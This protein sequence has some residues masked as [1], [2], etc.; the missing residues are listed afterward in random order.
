MSTKAIILSAAL[1]VVYLIH[2]IAFGQLLDIQVFADKDV[3][4]IGDTIAVSASGHNLGPGMNV[5]VH[6]AILTPDGSIHEAP[7]WNT[8]FAPFLEDFHLP[9]SFSYPKSDIGTYVVGELGFPASFP[10]DYLL[11]AAL[12]EPWTLEFLTEVS[13]APFRIEAPAVPGEDFLSH[14]GFTR[15]FLYYVP[16]NLP[17][18][19]VPLVFML[20]GAMSMSEGAMYGTTEERFNRLADRDKV[21]VVYPQAIDG[22]WNDCF[23]R[24][25]DAPDDVGFISSLIDHLSSIHTIDAQRIYAAGY[26]NGGMMSLR[27]AVELSGK[28]AAV[29]STNG[30]LPLEGE[31][32]DPVN[33]VGVLY[34]GG[35]DDP[36]VPFDGSDS[37]MSADETVDFWVSFL[38]T[39]A[40]PS[41]MQIPDTVPEDD[42]TVTVYTYSNGREQTQVSFYRI[43]GGGHPWPTP[44]TTGSP[45][46]NKNRDISGCDEVW[47]FFA[48]HTLGSVAGK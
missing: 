33:P 13:S 23:S 39:D 31:C 27:L 37:I 10:G 45:L 26:S 18:S 35:T 30:P 47:W 41:V 20:H 12:T 3:Y 17:S 42:C 21:I 38:E 36:I 14:D 48:R 1:S 6:V 4:M 32:S 11:V 25:G 15:R 46:G 43:E 44:S 2:G 5:D 7:D 24:S 40:T 8:D 29:A 19:A 22:R 16:N 28:I 9:Q 34:I